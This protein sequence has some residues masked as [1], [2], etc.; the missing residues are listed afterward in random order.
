MTFELQPGEKKLSHEFIELVDDRRTYPA[1]LIL[2]SRRL[3]VTYARTPRVWLWALAWMIALVASVAARARE[4]RV[5][6][7]MRRDRFRSVEQGD[8][9]ILVFHDDGE[10]YAH[11][12]FAIKSREPLN[13]WQARMS[14]WSSG[15]AEDDDV[16]APLPPARLVDR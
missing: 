13:A 2:T 3:V 10:G 1:S 15:T 6:Y 9:G 16:P 12:S 11:T 5:R 14:G 8:G 4:E 7:Q